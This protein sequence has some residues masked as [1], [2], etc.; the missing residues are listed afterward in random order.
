M[1]PSFYSGTGLG[2][3][4]S[5]CKLVNNSKSVAE[6]RMK[7]HLKTWIIEDDIKQI[8]SLNFNSVRL[9][10][11]YWNVIHDPYHLYAPSDLQLS[12]YY[13]DWIFQMTLKYNLSILI[14]IHG[15][16]GSQNG[17][18]HSGCSKTPTWTTS[19]NIELT[20]DA[21]ESILKRYSNYTNLLGIELLNEPG[22]IIEAN[23]HNLLESFY[24]SSYSLI[25]RYHPSLYIIY[26][27]LYSD[28]YSIWDNKFL[29]PK[30][31]NI[32]VDWHLYHWQQQYYNYTK[33]Q[34]I[35][36]VKEWKYLI[37]DYHKINSFYS[38][39]P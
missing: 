23:S 28:Y 34:H 14:D 3:G 10:I 17:I 38:Y 15:G 4:G 32:I 8:K 13:L 31:Y 2:W 20:L 35:N 22:L 16:P 19:R 6:E 21:I 1:N 7:E 25:R 26:N 37:N 30:Y 39:I 18:D 12:Y 24:R 5:L 27:E 29:E 9:P 36:D 11:G 33:Q